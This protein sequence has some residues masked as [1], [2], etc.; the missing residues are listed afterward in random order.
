MAS[1]AMIALVV[2]ADEPALFYSSVQRAEMELE[3]IDVRNGVYPIAY[4]TSGQ[5]FS[6]EA[7]GDRVRIVPVA[8]LS[9]QPDQLRD[10]LLL[11]LSASGFCDIGADEALESLLIRCTSAVK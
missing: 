3:A 9:P 5:V 2:A 8:G 4:D 10:L 11:Y 1:E 7:I 6:V